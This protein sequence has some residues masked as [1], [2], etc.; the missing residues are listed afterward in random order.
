[1][2]DPFL[3]AMSQED[4]ARSPSPSFS[5]KENEPTSVS[6]TFSSLFA[7][8]NKLLQPG[9][10]TL[11]AS[12]TP[13]KRARSPSVAPSSSKPTKRHR[14]STSGAIASLADSIDTLVGGIF[15]P[16]KSVSFSSP[17]KKDKAWKIVCQEEG[18]SPQ[19]L[20]H[21]RK[22]FRGDPEIASEYLSFDNTTEEM[23]MARSFWL[24]DELTRVRNET[25]Q[26]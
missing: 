1:M 15:A 12:K 16:P 10:A 13:A 21:A 17:V 14:P 19:S 5:D 11:T 23:R 18:L 4:R 7:S 6:V 20:A 22:V 9:E 24:S 25:H 8:S 2:I 26:Y 3:E